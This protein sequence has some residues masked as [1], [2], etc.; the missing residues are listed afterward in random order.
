MSEKLTLPRVMTGCSGTPPKMNSILEPL[1]AILAIF[2]PLGMT[3]VILSLQLHKPAP[4][5]R[6]ASASAR[7]GLPQNRAG[8]S[9]TDDK[10]A[11]Q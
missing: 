1:L 5:C 11:A 4:G 10:H 2:F 6:K 9:C 8:L 3:Y 7:D